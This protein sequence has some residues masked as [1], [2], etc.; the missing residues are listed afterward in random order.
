MPIDDSPSRL[1]NILLVD[2]DPGDAGL[3][4]RAFR[5]SD[6]AP[7]LTWLEDGEAALRYLRREP[8]YDAAVRPDLILLDLNMPKV[9]GRGV[10]A[11]IRADPALTDLPVVLLTTS[12]ADD[13]VLAGYRLHAN[14]YICKPI[15]LNELVTIVSA[16]QDFWFRVAT[17]PRTGQDSH[18]AAT[19]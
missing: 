19:R 4:R 11:A 3:V 7:A 18:G 1:A 6:L 2:D 15:G 10:L 8:P 14:A 9:D 12:R 5:D 16:V 13:D 17:L